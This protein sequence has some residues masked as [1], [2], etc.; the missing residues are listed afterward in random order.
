MVALLTTSFYHHARAA[1]GCGTNLLVAVTIPL[2]SNH[3][4]AY[5]QKSISSRNITYSSNGQFI[6]YFECQFS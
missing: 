2:G 1:R 6:V 5:S 3:C 4:S